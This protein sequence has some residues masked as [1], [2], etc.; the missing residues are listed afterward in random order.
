[1]KKILFAFLLVK[2]SISF[3]QGPAM[4]WQKRFG[5]SKDEIVRDVH[6][7]TDGGYIV[8]GSTS[9][10]SNDG[11]VLLNHSS[12]SFPNDM[13]VMKVDSCGSMEWQRSLGGSNDDFA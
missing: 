5:G 3:S 11:D 12:F 2:F 8:V 9:S 4:Q 7:T 1:M 10:F 13:W 6:Q